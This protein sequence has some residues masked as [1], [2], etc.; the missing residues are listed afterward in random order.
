M[1]VRA[2]RKHRISVSPRDLDGVD[3]SAIVRQVWANPR[4]V[5]VR[6]DHTTGDVDFIDRSIPPTDK[7][8]NIRAALAAAGVT[9][10]DRGPPDGVFS[11]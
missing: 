2:L 10:V 4:K 7:R 8:S 3:F 1:K 6:V 9:A 5:T 11:P